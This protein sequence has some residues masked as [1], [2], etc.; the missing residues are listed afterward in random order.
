[1]EYVLFK[2]EIFGFTFFSI[3][4]QADEKGGV[5]YGRVKVSYHVLGARTFCIELSV[6]TGAAF[7][8]MNY[9]RQLKSVAY[10]LYILALRYRSQP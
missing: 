4:S 10:Y 1:M 2:A 7:P 8:G 9:L 6:E 5:T 3:P